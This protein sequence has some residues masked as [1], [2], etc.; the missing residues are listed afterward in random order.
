[1]GEH[2]SAVSW[3]IAK[4]K[5]TADDV[6]VVKCKGYLDRGD[7]ERIKAVVRLEIPPSTK[8]LVLDERVDI[9]VLTVAAA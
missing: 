9:A 6:L 1:M 5:L 7:G 8:I 3:E 4:L 2:V